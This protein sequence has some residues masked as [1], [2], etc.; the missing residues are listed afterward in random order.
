MS[1][2]RPVEPLIRLFQEVFGEV[3]D[4]ASLA[5][6]RR[7]A[8]AL[9]LQDNDALWSIIA[10]LEYYARLYEAMPERIRWASEGSLEATRREVGGAN[11]AL[12][13]QHRD[14]LERC[15]ATI[16]LAE[17]LIQEHEARYREALANL[18]EAFLTTLSARL[19]AQVAHSAGNR[20]IG[21]VAVSGRDQQKRLDEVVDRFGRAVDVAAARVEEM[22]T[23]MERRFARAMRGLWLSGAVV[24]C[25][26]V[27]V[28]GGWM[29]GRWGRHP[30]GVV[31]QAVQGRSVDGRS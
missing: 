19:T 5:R 12:M 18:N 14:A 17:K 15:K 30:S 16:T 29:D 6:M 27:L 13:Q 4:E 25:L 23:A 21:A 9:N 3:P 10:V 7:V 31:G 2:R 8:G 20:L 22:S 11:D 1:R 28:A 24:L 26:I